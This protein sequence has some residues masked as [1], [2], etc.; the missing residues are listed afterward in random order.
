MMKK[1][2]APEV[3]VMECRVEDV[4]TASVQM[5]PNWTPVG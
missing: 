4:V 5:P 2:E 1:Y 3:E